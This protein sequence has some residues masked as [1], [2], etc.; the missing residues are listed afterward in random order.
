MDQKKE[1]KKRN[2]LFGDVFFP[3]GVKFTKVG[4]QLRGNRVYFEGIQ[5]ETQSMINQP[6]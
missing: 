2:E 5:S 3:D 6:E 4:Q 1:K